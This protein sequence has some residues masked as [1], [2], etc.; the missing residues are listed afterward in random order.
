MICPTCFLFFDFALG[1]IRNL[2]CF[3]CL[4]LLICFS[5]I[6]TVVGIYPSLN[7]E[8]SAPAYP[9]AKVWNPELSSTIWNR[10]YNAP[11]NSQKGP[12]SRSLSLGNS[13]SSHT[14]HKVRVMHQQ[15]DEPSGLLKVLCFN[16][17]IHPS[18][19]FINFNS[20]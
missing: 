3:H 20:S 8:S 7:T 17:R 16:L 1:F 18:F 10:S 9:S 2:Q 19:Q 5:S 15:S 14:F 13:T 12:L 11:R 6:R 4:H